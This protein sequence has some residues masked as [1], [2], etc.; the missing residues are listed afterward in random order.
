MALLHLAE[1][2]VF[3]GLLWLLTV[4]HGVLGTALASSLR[5]GVDAAVIF[6]L[7]Q[8]RVAM[9]TLHWRAA[10]GPAGVAVLL[11]LAG[12]WPTD[13]AE[14]VALAGL[15]ALPSR[16]GRPAAGRQRQQPCAAAPGAATVSRRRADGPHERHHQPGATPAL[17]PSARRCGA[18]SRRASTGWP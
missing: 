16:L 5:S 8:R 13:W 10:A 14:S 18:G 3:V 6:G 9:G 17:P 1:L 7:A 2:P 11:L 4:Q 15:A 12:L